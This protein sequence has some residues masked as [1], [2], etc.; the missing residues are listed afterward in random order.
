MFWIRK[1]KHVKSIA[2][3]G[4]PLAD[5]I[6]GSQFSKIQ[7]NKFIININKKGDNCF[8][9]ENEVVLVENIVLS[10]NKYFLVARRF[11]D[12]APLFNSPVESNMHGLLQCSNLSNNL[13][14][15]EINKITSK[16]YRLPLKN[17]TF[18]VSPVIHFENYDE[19]Q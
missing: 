11:K 3:E 9:L 13:K 16:L 15:Y 6:V 1:K 8:L 18:M 12:K 10:N 7:F 5:G 14:A 2:H 19:Y 17:N 4:G